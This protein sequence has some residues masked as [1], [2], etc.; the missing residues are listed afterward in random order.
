MWEVHLASWSVLMV[1]RWRAGKGC[2]VYS[3]W[4]DR[5]SSCKNEMQVWAPAGWVLRTS[6]GG[7]AWWTLSG[8]WSCSLALFMA[9]CWRHYLHF[10]PL[11]IM[12]TLQRWLRMQARVSAS[13][14]G[15][16]E[17][18]KPLHRDLTEGVRLT[19]PTLWA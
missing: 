13:T 6:E 14:T 1:W 7:G 4:C 5:R 12:L 10:F 17:I 9:W 8:L 2:S 18:R 11:S 15:H 19:L 3:T 16:A